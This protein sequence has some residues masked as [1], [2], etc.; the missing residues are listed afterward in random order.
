MERSTKYNLG[1]TMILKT[2][3][4]EDTVFI[5]GIC[6][7]YITSLGKHDVPYETRRVYYMVTRNPYNPDTAMKVAE[8][9]LKPAEVSIASPKLEWFLNA[10]YRYAEDIN[11][12]C[13]YKNKIGLGTLLLDPYKMDFYWNCGDKISDYMT[14]EIGDIETKEMFISVLESFKKE[15]EKIIGTH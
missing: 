7:E 9:D 11:D 2:G 14:I 8:E 1:D 12:Q 4:L 10:A 15:L 13:I 3:Q 6:E 5:V